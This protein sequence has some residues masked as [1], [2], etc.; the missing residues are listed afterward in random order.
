MEIKRKRNRR[1]VQPDEVP[2]SDGAMTHC[3]CQKVAG[4]LK[5]WLTTLNT[6]LLHRT[7]SRPLL[8]YA[9]LRQKQPCLC[10]RLRLE[11]QVRLETRAP[12]PPLET[13]RIALHEVTQPAH[14]CYRLGSF[15]CS[16][17]VRKTN[18]SSSLA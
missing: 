11:A 6:R 17:A 1:S 16:L 2:G 3:A 5:R 9:P 14:H 8:R 12:L 18:N 13:R 4:E 15:D 7:S 10:V